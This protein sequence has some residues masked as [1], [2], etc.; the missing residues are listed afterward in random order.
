MFVGLCVREKIVRSEERKK[1]K[2]MQPNPKTQCE[3]ERKEEKRKE[4]EDEEDQTR[5]DLVWKE[6]KKRR[7]RKPNS[8][9]PVKK[10]KVKNYG[11]LLTSGSLSVCLI[12]KMPLETKIM[13]AN[14]FCFLFLET[15]FWEYKEK[16]IFLY[17]LNQKR[18]WLVEIK[19]R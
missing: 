13:F 10:K 1:E 5:P 12:T 2:K 16:T 3:K 18:V 15:F 11:W 9:N 17:F 4:K 8:P 6:K 7:R 19:K 14:N